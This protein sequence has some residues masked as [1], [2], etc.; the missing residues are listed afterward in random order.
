MTRTLSIA[1]GIFVL[2]VAA[3]LIGPSFVDWNKY[4]PLIIDQAK[5]AAGYDIKIDGDIKMSLLPSP[6]AK[7]EG[8]S[9]LAPRGQEPVLLNMKQTEVV[10]NVMPLIGGNISIDTIR[11]V[12]PDIRLEKLANGQNSWMSD[13]LLAPAEN[14]ANATDSATGGSKS[15]PQSTQNVAFDQLT[16]QDGRVSYVDRISG[17]TQTAET[18]NVSMKADTLQGPFDIN[19]SLVYAGQTIKVDAKTKAPKGASKETDVKAKISLSD[20]NAFIDFGGVVAMEPM[21]VQGQVEAKADNLASVISTF[22]GGQPSAALSKKLSFSG[23][24]TATENAVNAQDMDVTFGDAKGKGGL[25]LS[26]IKDQN[27]AQL[28]ADLA[29]EGVI[30]LDQ[31]AQAKQPSQ[32][33]VEERV[34]KGEKLS[35]QSSFIPETLSLPMPVDASINVSLEGVQSGGKTFRGITA[36]ITKMGPA[37]DAKAKILEIPGKTSAD[38]K[39]SVR[40]ASTSKSGE[41]GVTYADPS[42][43]FSVIGASEQLPTMLR[44]FAPA[45]DKNPALEIWKTARFDLAGSVT[46][47]TVNLSNS[48]VKLDDTTVAVAASYKPNGTGGKPD[49]F[50]DL[51]TDTLDLDAIMSR[52]NGQK[53]QAVQKDTAAKADVKKALEPVRGIN[54]PMNATFDLSAQKAIYNAQP[55]TGI[56]IKGNASGNMLKLDVASAQDYMG[57]TASLKGAVGNLSDL[58]GI[59][60]QFYGKT[61]DVK[62]LMQSFKMDTSKLPAQIS[63]AEANIKA[64]GKADD[65]DF[66]AS[67]KAL[68]GELEATGKMTGLLDK[69]SFSNLT[70]GANHPNM[71]KAIQIVNPAFTGGP[72]MERPFDF[73][74]KAVKEGDAYNLTSLKA[75][76]GST[77]ITGDVKVSTAGAKPSIS[78]TINAGAI[79]LDDLLGAKKSGGGNASGGSAGTSNA[80]SGGGK[81]SRDTIETGWMHSANIDLGLSAQSI[82]Y[83]GWNLEKP[84]T[85]LT[86]KDGSLNV[87]NLQAGLFGGTANLSAK[88]QDPA[89]EKQPLSLAV[90]S[91][92]NDVALESLAGAMSGSKLL[93][94]SGDVSLDFDVQATGLSSYALVSALK[95]KANLNGTN[96]NLKGFDLAQIALA[97]VDTG[98]PLDRLNSLVG[99]A[100]TG[101]ETRFDTIKGAYNISEGIATI[102]SMNMDGPAAT[103]NSTGNVNLPQWT[104]DTIHA[105]TLKQAKEEGAFNVAIKGSLSNPGNTFGRGLFNDVITRRAQDKVQEKVMEKLPDLVGGKLGDKLQGLGILPS[106]QAPAVAPTPA[107]PAPAPAAAPTPEAVAPAPQAAPAQAEPAA[108]PV[109][110]AP[111]PAPE[112]PKS[113]EEQFKE[114]PEKAIKGVLDGLLQ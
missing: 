17:K 25:K 71:V 33:S 26:N 77:T 62:S 7:I 16:I 97:F 12:S 66:D 9:V 46:P 101:G 87:D 5:T 54:V 86:L 47:S 11:F 13:K 65:L 18:I 58:T 38:A 2:L 30:N 96:V 10:I 78:G 27:P 105:I 95:G 37:V 34:A 85:K 1:L 92:M 49:V 111:A 36:Q 109:A 89:D 4:K 40:F 42:V 70:V 113:V 3:L 20:A 43:T 21:E 69:P 61:S 68:Q 24:V 73:Y 100:V 110:P 91:K 8:L 104:I 102:S 52:L 80:S 59:D 112:Q 82:K 63:T 31:L 76:L 55:I 28:D 50:V 84:N 56:R 99:G 75:S 64:K 14:D 79:A 74:T 48:T 83:G 88:V 45:Q 32:K 19:G 93:K 90:N 98:K 53:T 103:I 106:K 23:L 35:A 114:D 72:G 57:A 108:Q 15:S 81:W 39:G 94:A 29:F 51:T 107:V 44:A 22:T 60:L 41:K 6:R 67:V